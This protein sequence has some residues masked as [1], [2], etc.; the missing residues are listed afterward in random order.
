VVADTAGR[1]SGLRALE[2][3][4]SI[5]TQRYN[6]LLTRQQ[7]LT[8]RIASPSPG[9]RL[10][11]AA[12]P[13]TNPTTLSPIFLIPPGMVVFGLIGGIFILVR[14]RFDSTLRGEAE[15]EAA[16]KVPCLGLIP[17]AAT[18]HARRLQQ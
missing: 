17:Q 4:V 10:L 1:L 15:A 14:Q 11:S 6:D 3:Q 9:V 5:L 16:L 7:D 8:R 12:W 13:P 18:T 2:P